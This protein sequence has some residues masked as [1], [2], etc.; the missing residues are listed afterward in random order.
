MKQIDELYRNMLDLS[1]PGVYAYVQHSSRKVF[2]SYSR[3]I[4]ASVSRNIQEHKYLDYELVI[5]DIDAKDLRLSTSNWI[6]DYRNKGYTILNERI[7]VQY[8]WI[9]DITKD[10]KVRTRLVNS[11]YKAIEEHYFDTIVLAQEFVNSYR[12]TD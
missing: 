11:R 2:I 4:I 1:I 3:N 5:L 10:F 9:I 6:H 12:Y 7:P 8:K